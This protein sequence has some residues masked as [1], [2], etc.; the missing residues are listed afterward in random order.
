MVESISASLSGPLCRRLERSWLGSPCG[1]H[2]Q[3]GAAEETSSVSGVIRHGPVVALE[4][5]DIWQMSGGY[6]VSFQ[7]T[8]ALLRGD[9]GGPEE[10]SEVNSISNG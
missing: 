2:T 5:A 1:R 3:E 9:P 8:H 6:H 10:A 4:L 7:D